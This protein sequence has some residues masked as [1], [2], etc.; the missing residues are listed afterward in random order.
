MSVGRRRR[1]PIA[2]A[3]VVTVAALAA[4]CGFGRGE[5]DRA[6]RA[7]LAVSGALEDCGSGTTPAATSFG[8]NDLVM[9]PAALMAFYGA[10]HEPAE[11]FR[12]VRGQDQAW[13]VP[14]VLHPG[15][16]LTLSVSGRTARHL[17]LVYTE[18]TRTARNVRDG[19]RKVT[20]RSCSGDQAAGT[21]GW[22]GGFLVDGPRCRLRV[23]ISVDGRAAVR[24]T[25]SFGSACAHR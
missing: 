16:T 4:G 23:R 20:F 14:V 6:P 5:P 19:D 15:T 12:P 18:R 21:T 2:G 22:A 3:A 11:S 10:V 17:S 1:W 7:A 24:R 13:K 9:G 8:P 25:I